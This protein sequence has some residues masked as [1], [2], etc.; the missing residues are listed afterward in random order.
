M[1][2]LPSLVPGG[3]GADAA[4]AIRGLLIPGIRRGIEETV[5]ELIFEFG[6]TL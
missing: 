3:A 2:D 1:I 5:Y 6:V 4:A